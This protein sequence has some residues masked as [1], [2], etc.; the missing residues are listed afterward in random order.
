MTLSS[1]FAAIRE[2][3]VKVVPAA[4]GAIEDVHIEYLKNTNTDDR[5]LKVEQTAPLFAA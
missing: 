5:A 1:K 3:Y 4:S 2:K